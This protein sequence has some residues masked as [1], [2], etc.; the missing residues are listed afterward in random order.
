MA[1]EALMCPGDVDSL[2]AAGDT[3][4]RS[5]EA[6]VEQRIMLPT[7]RHEVIVRLPN[8]TQLQGAAEIVDSP[9]F[10]VIARFNA[11]FTPNRVGGMTLHMNPVRG[12]GRLKSQRGTAPGR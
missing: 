4:A 5:G 8:G 11:L 12:V 2:A 3:L 1:R 10:V 6:V 9:E 7:G